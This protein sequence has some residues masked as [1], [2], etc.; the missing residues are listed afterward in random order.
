MACSTLSRTVFPAFTQEIWG[1]GLFYSFPS[2][3]IWGISHSSPRFRT[4]PSQGPQKCPPSLLSQT[5]QSVGKRGHFS[6]IH[7][8]FFQIHCVCL[9]FLPIYLK[10]APTPFASEQQ[11]GDMSLMGQVVNE[12]I[13]SD[14]QLLFLVLL[15]SGP[16][17]EGTESRAQ[18]EGWEG[19]LAHSR[20]SVL[21]GCLQLLWF[22]G[23]RR[24]VSF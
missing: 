20:D 1:P 12:D 5:P 21:G 16:T 3:L 10:F 23:K 15:C 24:R 14:S 4:A 8:L 19:V 18:V 6:P 9:E 2:K 11:C 13:F 7:H 22:Q 17:W